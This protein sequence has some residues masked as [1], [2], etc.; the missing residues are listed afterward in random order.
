MPH[1]RI[2]EFG[3]EL[4]NSQVGSLEVRAPSDVPTSVP[5]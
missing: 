1:C 5:G 2:A 4:D 3:E